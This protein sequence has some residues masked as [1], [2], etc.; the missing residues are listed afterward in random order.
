MQKKI[1]YLPISL[2]TIIISFNWNSFVTEWNESNYKYIPNIT[3]ITIFS[4]IS[5]YIFIRGLIYP[6]S[7]EEKISFLLPFNFLIIGIFTF[8]L[9]ITKLYSFI[10]FFNIKKKLT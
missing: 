4:I 1:Y 6:F 8:F 10:N 2:L 7:K 9:D 3:K 5:V